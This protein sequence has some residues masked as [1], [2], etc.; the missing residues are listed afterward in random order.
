MTKEVFT[1]EVRQANLIEPVPK[2]KL[3]KY[4]VTIFK[5]GKAG[6]NS[7]FIKF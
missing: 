6:Y 4:L 7:L 5:L 1:L 2:S 3:A